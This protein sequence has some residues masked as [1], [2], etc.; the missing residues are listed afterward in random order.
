MLE[1]I[2]KGSACVLHRYVCKYA[3]V[4][5]CMCVRMYV[6]TYVLMNVCACTFTYIRAKLHMCLLC[7]RVA[8]SAHRSERSL[9]LLASS[10]RTFVQLLS[11]GMFIYIYAYIYI[12]IDSV[13]QKKVCEM[14]TGSCTY[15]YTSAAADADFALAQCA[16]RFVAECRLGGLSF[17]YT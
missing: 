13:W 5:G 16:H 10:T 11:I 8:S 17:F 12:F 14:R 1:L 15:T 9:N 7:V 3:G 6:Y 2:L 4:Y